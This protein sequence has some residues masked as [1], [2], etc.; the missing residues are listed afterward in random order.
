MGKRG[1]A[2]ITVGGVPLQL[3]V[4]QQLGHGLVVRALPPRRRALLGATISRIITNE[5]LYHLF[6]ISLVLLLPLF[7]RLL[8][9]EGEGSQQKEKRRSAESKIL[10]HFCQ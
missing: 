9:A 10:G 3:V 2:Q 4:D 6:Y 1:R 7:C 8:L 5:S